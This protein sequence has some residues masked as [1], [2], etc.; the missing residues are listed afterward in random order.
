MTSRPIIAITMGDPA[1]VGPEI[2]LLAC[3]SPEIQ[4]ICRPVVIGDLRRLEQ[5]AGI[6][7]R[8]DVSFNVVERP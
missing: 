7:G 1:G 4:G 5:A 3:L 8:D 6:Q 2:S